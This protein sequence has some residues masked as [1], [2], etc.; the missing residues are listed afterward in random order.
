MLSKWLLPRWWQLWESASRT[1]GRLDTPTLWNFSRD[2][3]LWY[4]WGW[5]Y[6]GSLDWPLGL[7]CKSTPVFAYPGPLE[8]SIFAIPRLVR[9]FPPTNAI[10]WN[11]GRIHLF[12]TCRTLCLHGSQFNKSASCQRP[13]LVWKLR[14]DWFSF[15]FIYSTMTQLKVK[16]LCIDIHLIIYNLFIFNLFICLFVYV[17]IEYIFLNYKPNLSKLFFYINS[18]NTQLKVY[19]YVRY[20]A[21]VQFV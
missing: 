10:P 13:W 17:Y 1:C 3:P 6:G 9:V 18:S 16:W 5:A 19:T 11:S 7:F 4:W 20:L 8:A 14:F 15:Q 12:C 2:T 21:H